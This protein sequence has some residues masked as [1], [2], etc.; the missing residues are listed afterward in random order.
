MSNENFC[1]LHVHSEYSQ[2][3]GFGTTDNYAKR[4]SQLGFKYLGLT[5]HGSIDG[6][7][8][9]QESCEKYNISPVLGCEGYI[10]PEIEEE[11]D[12]KG[13]KKI[14][15]GHICL[16][17]KNQKGFEN[18]CNIL[19]FANLEGF[20]YKPRF[21]FQTLLD[22][23]EGLIVSTACVQSFVRKFDNKGVEF[24]HTLHDILKDDLYCE[25]MPH[26]LQVQVQANNLKLKLA[27]K[28]GCKIIATND[29]HY[30]NKVDHKA[31]EV[32]LA[33]Q[34]KAKWED[35]KRWKFNIKG[36]HL[37]SAKEMAKSLKEIGFYKKEYLY[38]T[39]E[40]AEKCSEFKIPKRKVN[41][42]R[43]KGVPINPQ[44]E[45]DFLWSLC[46]EGY[47]EKYKSNIKKNREYYNRFKEEYRLITSKKFH[48]YFLIVWELV[49]WCKSKN[50]L[51]GPGRGSVGGSLIAYLL[52]IT[53]VDPIEHNLMFS[54][55]I[56]E[57]RIDYPD[58]D[59]DFEDSQ[60]HLVKQHLESK[61]GEGKVAGVSSFNRMK[62]R[63]V[64]KNV[65]RVFDIHHSIINEFTKLVEDNDEGTGIQD[66]IE[67]WDKAKQ[68]AKEYPRVIRYA[69]KLEGIVF[70][71]SQ[72]AAALVLSKDDIGYS[73]RCN[74]IKRKDTLLVNWEKEDTEYVGLMKIDA[75]GLKLL[76][77]LS[78]AKKLIK[79]NHNENI[80]FEKIDLNDKAVLKEI[81]NGNT[82]GLFQL[83]TY[84]MTNLIKE[85]GVETFNHVSD[86]VALV[87]P[88]PLHSGMTADYIKRKHGRSWVKHHKVYEE[89][90][91][92][93]FGILIYQEQIMEV[94]S[95]VGGLP[96]STADNI[97]KIIGKKRSKKEFRPYKKQFVK[98][99]EKTQIFNREEANEFWEVLK[100][101][102]QYSFNRSHSVEYSTLAF[103]CA[104]LKK[105]YPTE[106]ICASLTFGA[107][108]KKSLLVEEAYRLGLKIIL[109][110][111]N[112]SDP[113]KWVAKRN[114]LYIP[115]IEVKGIGKVKAL[116]AAVAPTSSGIK[117]FFNKKQKKENTTH[118]GSLGK[119]LK[120]IGAYE[121]NE[122]P[123]SI[124]EKTK[125]LFEFRVMSS[126]KENY[127]NLYSLFDNKLQSSLLNPALKGDYKAL[128]SLKNKKG[129]VHKVKFKRHTN[130]LS[131]TSCNLRNEC[132]APVQPSSGIWNIVIT[133]EAPGPEEDK[134][135]RGFYEDA[136]AARVLWNSL[137]KK[138]PRKLF[139]VSNTNKCYPKE[140]R[141][142]SKDQIK[143]CGEK[144]LHK[145][146]K[147]IKP[148]L[149][150]AFGNTSRYYFTGEASGILNMSGKT[151]W[152]EKYSSWI[153]WCVHP[154]A[155]LHNP[156]NASYY[157][158]GIKQFKK[159][160]RILAPQI[161]AKK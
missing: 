65:G 116:E 66:A 121:Q 100:E 127:P 3:D 103:W 143:I 9:F 38:H 110:K 123:S 112:K 84:A 27:K 34:G 134:H 22:N 6:L 71:Y 90:T 58:I 161:R 109:P 23:I 46:T 130:L 138:Y 85:M 82:V 7:I 142:P 108:D 8:K 92:D 75:L 146:I 21:T 40:L 149:I 70:G 30:I 153:V 154:A 88:G 59:I 111:V 42:P 118:K 69:K 2:L 10:I 55:F 29:C 36:L 79:R 60:R 4:A 15:R 117:K 89:I 56:S 135:G 139:H 28:T 33:I 107:R 97:R 26:K 83:N 86:A 57:D 151:E 140:S 32:L 113:I 63:A 150:L 39:I 50:V 13:K 125:E 114:K 157:L 136:P 144:Y 45:K 47:K 74:L 62:A 5:D 37:R 87:R 78:E 106:F 96:Y 20:Y 81:S 73:G 49:N 128:T 51:V 52:G 158:I 159:M 147:K 99:C 124:T 77:I 145:E 53:A 160:L 12:K 41:L 155:T 80:D 148:I 141:R 104:F 91:K 95:K 11:E 68:F 94:I 105:Y 31:H 17:V 43:V 25:I 132:I 119:L 48:R 120:D 156:D 126:T 72:H 102:A 98:G 64:V 1:H 16:F 67:S 133:G 122:K 76:S 35:P 131:C 44:K 61:Y 115:F 93:T 152:N 137:G 129:I 14:Q 18:L 19:T 24:F 101:H 54:R